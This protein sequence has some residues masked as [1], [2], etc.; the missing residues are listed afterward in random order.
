M[1]SLDALAASDLLSARAQP[2]GSAY[3]MRTVSR[4]VASAPA[5]WPFPGLDAEAVA[6]LPAELA[7]AFQAN[8]I[9]VA[10]DTFEPLALERAPA[11]QHEGERPGIAVGRPERCRQPEHQRRLRRC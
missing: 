1:P 10:A 5:C 2:A 6:R 11:L 7:A 4:S 8:R 9:A 3:S